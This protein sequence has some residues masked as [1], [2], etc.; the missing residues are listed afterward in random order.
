MLVGDVLTDEVGK[1]G[2]LFGVAVVGVDLV[3]MDVLLL[4]IVANG[5]SVV[6][7]HCWCCY[8]P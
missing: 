7:A 1:L 8:L 3:G 4:L 5:G 2:A 6:V